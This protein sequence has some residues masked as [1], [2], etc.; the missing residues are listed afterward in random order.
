MKS[1][2]LPFKSKQFISL[3]SLIC[4]HRKQQRYVSVLQTE[5]KQTNN[6]VGYEIRNLGCHREEKDVN[7]YLLPAFISPD[8]LTWGKN[9]KIHRI[10]KDLITKETLPAIEYTDGVNAWFIKGKV[11]RIDKDDKGYSLHTMFRDSNKYWTDSKGNNYRDEK[12]HHGDLENGY[13]DKHK[14]FISLILPTIVRKNGTKEWYKNGKFHRDERDENGFTLPAIIYSNGTREWYKDGE[15]HR[16][17]KENGFTLPAVVKRNGTKEWWQNDKPFRDD[18]DEDGYF[19]PNMT[20][21]DKHKVWLKDKNWAFHR[22]EK[23]KNG[24]TLPAIITINGTKEWHIENRRRRDDKDKNGNLLPTVEKFYGIGEW[25][26]EHRIEKVRLINKC[27]YLKVI[28]KFIVG[29]RKKFHEDDNFYT[30]LLDID[31]DEE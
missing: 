9:G 4:N 19:L 2:F 11:F 28:Y 29:C 30:D 26:T 1:T 16:D 25:H 12:G 6:G 7:G 14:N 3:L 23:D 13:F 8:F 27:N 15:K 18:K 24:L 22:D 31:S 5:I 21:Q 17:E 10:E 20:V